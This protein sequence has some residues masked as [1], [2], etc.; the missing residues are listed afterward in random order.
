MSIL[1]VVYDM[2]V[3]SICY[4]F[5]WY[6]PSMS[7]VYIIPVSGICHASQWY[8]TRLSVRPTER[9]DQPGRRPGAHE[10][11]KCTRSL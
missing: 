8:M 1:S 4:T 2:P 7:V 10:F 6:M 3:G 5:Q 9:G 11:N